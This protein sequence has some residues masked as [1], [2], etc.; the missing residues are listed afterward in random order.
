[1]SEPIEMG[2]RD[3]LRTKTELLS[4]LANDTR[5]IDLDYTGNARTYIVFYKAAGG[6]SRYVSTDDGIYTFHCYGASRHA[7][8]S[9]ATALAGVLHAVDSEAYNG[10]YLYHAEVLNTYYQPD[11]TWERYIIS[12]RVRATTDLPV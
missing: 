12:A 2:I 6:M 9:L 4:L 11:N 5:K 3:M 1:M 7:A 8:M 10:T